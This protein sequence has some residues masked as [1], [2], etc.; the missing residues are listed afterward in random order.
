MNE[1]GTFYAKNRQEWREWL[2]KNHESE[3]SV[4]L[5][6]D[7][8]SVRTMRWEDI[9]Q[10]A[11]CFGWIDSTARK[12]S[13]TQSK[14]YVSKRRPKSIWSK[15]NKAHIQH[16][17]DSNLMM[18]AGLKAVE[19]AQQNGSWNALDKTDAL[20][21]PDELRMQFKN[22][23]KAKNYYDNLSA[24]KKKMILYWIYSAKQAE[25]QSRRIMKTIQSTEKGEMPVR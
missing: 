2:I 9:V 5:V 15:I 17:I 14:I 4:W 3:S 6:H 21:L 7:K 19:V 8:G 13:D 1:V 20:E 22:N 16:L 10:E 24:S 11:L 18:P 25:T 23:E 12:H